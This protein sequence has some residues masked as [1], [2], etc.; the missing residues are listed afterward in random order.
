MKACW[1][2]ITLASNNSWHNFKKLHYYLYYILQLGNGIIYIYIDL[3]IYLITESF[4][5]TSECFA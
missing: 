2:A 4:R 1:N 3:S 5:N